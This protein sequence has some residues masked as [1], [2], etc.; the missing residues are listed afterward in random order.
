MSDVLVSGGLEDDGSL[1]AAQG[2]KL[3]MDGQVFRRVVVKLG[4][5]S[6]VFTRRVGDIGPS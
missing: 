2:W 5:L 4:G 3:A 6:R 1:A